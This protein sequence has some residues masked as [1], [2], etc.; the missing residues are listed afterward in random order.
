[1]ASAVKSN[2]IYSGIGPISPVRKGAQHYCFSALYASAIVLLITSSVSTYAGKIYKHVDENGNV[3]FSDQPPSNDAEELTL[4]TQINRI[5]SKAINTKE[6][7][8]LIQSLDEKHAARVEK[9]ESHAEQRRAALAQLKEAKQ[10]LIEA[11][12]IKEGDRIGVKGGGTRL[13]E[14]YLAR[15]SQA[16]AAVA[17]AEKLVGN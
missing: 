8:A 15:I 12:E 9:R 16:E 14:A 17:A 1:M 2:G 5:E 4:D 11:K 10:N 3:S 13:S 7:R 6:R